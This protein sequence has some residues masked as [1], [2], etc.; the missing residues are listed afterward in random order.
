MALP[1]GN[2]RITNFEIKEEIGAGT[3]GKVYR[4]IYNGVDVAFKLFNNQTAD[5]TIET[6][7]LSKLNH[8]NIIRYFGY[9]SEPPGI[10]IE[11]LKTDL[12]K[13]LQ[14]NQ[15]LPNTFRLK[16][17]LEI[18]ITI[19]YLHSHNPAIIHCDLKSA[20]ILFDS[21]YNVKICDFGLITIKSQEKVSGQK[22]SLFW[23]A[24]ELL[25]GLRYDEKVDVYSFG[26]VMGEILKATYPQNNQMNVPIFID[27]VLKGARPLLPQ[28]TSPSLAQL[29]NRCWNLYP[30]NRPSFT[31]IIDALN[32]E[33]LDPLNKTPDSTAFDFWCQHYTKQFWV[34]WDGFIDKLNTFI[35]SRLEPLPPNGDFNHFNNATIEQLE[36]FDS[37]N[38]VS[39]QIARQALE[40]K[41]AHEQFN[42]NQFN[43]F[44][45]TLLTYEVEGLPIKK[46][47]EVNLENFIKVAN[48][49]G[50]LIKDNYIYNLRV[51]VS[52]LCEKSW[53]FGGLGTREAET[54]L[55]SGQNGT[56]L[57][58]FSSSQLG[59]FTISRKIENQ[60]AHSRIKKLNDYYFFENDTHI[61]HQSIQHL[62][63]ANKTHLKL[64]EP[65]SG[66]PFFKKHITPKPY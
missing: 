57:I 27:Q 6:F 29:I 40:R 50:P 5:L 36:K 18:A 15:N 28:G 20:N 10:I 62:I 19:N 56:Y 46:S 35:N 17:A 45:Q 49:F 43:N 58:R 7:T 31:E 55:E 8:P 2:T 23:M 30:Q 34:S 44:L 22:G 52:L 48:Y 54:K 47:D 26:I 39:R 65:C 4:A 64:T 53:F 61:H 42:N 59:V 41:R 3:F 38:P 13:F 60:I 16:I 14:N 1:N 11:Y 12:T 66:S 51:Q 9:C 21:N 33:F 24:P 25:V 32:R 37:P 63:N